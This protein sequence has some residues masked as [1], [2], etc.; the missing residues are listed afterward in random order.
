[1]PGTRVSHIPTSAFPQWPVVFVVLVVLASAVVIG[2]RGMAHALAAGAPG[3]ALSWHGGNAEALAKFNETEADPAQKAARA[4]RVLARQPLDGRA[5]R[6][7]AEVADAAGDQAR[8]FALYS[9][10][11]EHSPRDRLSRAWLADHAHARGDHR[12]ALR[13]VD[14]L[15]RID[16]ELRQPVFGRLAL[17][18]T[19]HRFR[20][21]LVTLLRADPPWR[22]Q[23][24]AWWHA[25]PE[26]TPKAALEDIHRA[27][28]ASGT[29][30]GG[31]VRASRVASLLEEQRWYEAYLTWAGGID[32]SD[33]NALGPIVNDGFERLLGGAFDWRFGQGTGHRTGIG[34]DNNGTR[35]LRLEL[36]GHDV[37]LGKTGQLMLLAPGRHVV[38][39]RVRSEGLRTE[40]GLVIAVTCASAPSKLTGKSPPLRESRDW[41]TVAFPVSVPDDCPAQWLGVDFGSPA[42]ERHAAGVVWLDDFSVRSPGRPAPPG[43]LR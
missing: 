4:R 14:V 1:M 30:L 40:R 41:R 11:I 3:R 37:A 15:M 34:I 35:A 5:Y 26:S 42:L 6:Q 27:L 38:S 16:A 20:S 12:V 36:L 21:A 25:E 22:A 39:L 2:T 28:R 31:V 8:A 18:A 32:P 33:W 24:L 13:H 29:P 10:A 23:F 7:L 9:I 17:L 19:D 43:R